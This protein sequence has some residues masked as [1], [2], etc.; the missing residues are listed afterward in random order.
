ME[1][2]ANDTLIVSSAPH[3]VS[4]VDTS[5]IMGTVILALVP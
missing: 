5:R 4:E 3:L 2:K 1:N